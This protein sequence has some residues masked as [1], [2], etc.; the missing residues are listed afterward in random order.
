MSF[1]ISFVL[2]YLIGSISGAMIISKV[3]RLPD[4]R[5]QGSG[6]AGTT[7]MLRTAGKKAAIIVLLIDLLKGL[8]AVW[9]GQLVGCSYF[10]MGLIAFAA[11]LGHVFPVFFQFKGGKGVA[12][13]LGAFFGLSFWFG[14]CVL[15]AWIIVAYIMRFASLASVV[16]AVLAPIF[17]LI[18]SHNGY[19]IGS[20]LIAALIIYK[21]LGNIE[22]LRNG[23]ESKINFGRS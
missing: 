10:E 20:I 11:V 19:L 3:F 12:T 15:I 23:T 7:N 21:H 13:A 9:I 5:T 1:I 8:L 2:A 22:R 14:L 16:A 6:N 4:P 17:I 18:G